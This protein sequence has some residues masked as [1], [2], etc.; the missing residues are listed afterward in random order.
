VTN[1]SHHVWANLHG[2][3]PSQI[4]FS[5]PLL[6]F[7]AI[8]MWCNFFSYDNGVGLY[9]YIVFNVSTTLCSATWFRIDCSILLG[10]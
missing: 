9:S 3:G 4:L 8:D 10:F 2:H 7:W 6:P 5:L 1:A